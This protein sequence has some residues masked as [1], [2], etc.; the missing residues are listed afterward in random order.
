LSK[1][2]PVFGAFG[3]SRLGTTF[4]HFFGAKKFRGNKHLGPDHRMENEKKN[5]RKFPDNN[6]KRG[7]FFAHAFSVVCESTKIGTP[8]KPPPNQTLDIQIASTENSE[9]QLKQNP[10][11]FNHGSGGF[12]FLK[13]FHDGFNGD[14]PLISINTV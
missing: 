11:L 8:Q 6:P 5:L 10:C 13:G 14:S 12:S 1:I 3:S 9:F 7:D 2:F 4:P